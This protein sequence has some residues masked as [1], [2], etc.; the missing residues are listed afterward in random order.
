M[1]FLCHDEVT[2]VK[3]IWFFVLR[4]WKCVQWVAEIPMKMDGLDGLEWSSPKTLRGIASFW[5]VGCGFG[6]PESFQESLHGE[7][8]L[9]DAMSEK[10]TFSSGES[11]VGYAD[12]SENECPSR[13]AMYDLVYQEAIETGMDQKL[14][15][16]G[17]IDSQRMKIL[18][19]LL[20]ANLESRLLTTGRAAKACIGMF[21]AIGFILSVTWT[22]QR[23]QSPVG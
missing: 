16:L 18:S 19:T 7:C 23:T 21:K 6:A 17:Q 12:S 22:P 15:F 11:M 9:N 14:K 8:W 1:S 5:A 4:R 2:W 13:H 10:R 3:K 20:P